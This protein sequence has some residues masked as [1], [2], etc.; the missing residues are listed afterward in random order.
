MRK[1]TG[2][3]KI[4]DYIIIKLHIKY[5]KYKV[6]AA[7]SPTL[8]VKCRI[9]SFH[10]L[11]F[12]SMNPIE[13]DFCMTNP[14]LCLALS[15]KHRGN[16][17]LV[18]WSNGE[19]TGKSISNRRRSSSRNKNGSHVSHILL[20][21]SSGATANK[22]PPNHQTYLEQLPLPPFWQWHGNRGTLGVLYR[23]EGICHQ[24]APQGNMDLDPRAG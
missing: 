19:R 17:L 18:F 4:S 24:W 12:G 22:F 6:E 3:T 8:I 7:M 16:E 21:Q 23:C 5:F 2:K 1:A 10:D 13:S 14:I 15:P 11:F 9:W 20:V